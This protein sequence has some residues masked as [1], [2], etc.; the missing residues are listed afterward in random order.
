MSKDKRPNAVGSLMTNVRPFY[1]TKVHQQMQTHILKDGEEE[2][3]S[4]LYYDFL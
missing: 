1:T 3:D 4:C 2:K